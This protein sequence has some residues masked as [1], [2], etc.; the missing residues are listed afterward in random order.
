LAVRTRLVGFKETV[1]PVGATTADS[2]TVPAKLLTL[3]T[4]I[5][6]VVEE[7]AKTVS[8]ADE[9]EM[10]KSLKPP[11]SMVMVTG[12]ASVP[13]T[14]VTVTEYDPWLAVEAT[15]TVRV[16]LA[17]TMVGE[18]TTR[19]GLTLAVTSVLDVE[20]DRAT[21]PVNPFRPATVIIVLF[22]APGAT[23]RERAL[24]ES[25]KSVTWT[26]IDTV[27]ERVAPLESVIVP[28]TVPS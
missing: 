9:A 10:A 18:R 12:F 6:D 5:V 14:P 15:R 20:T 4:V 1:G 23:L 19:T 22:E 2:E 17:E 8:V 7:P 26:T 25:E 3:D 16:E 11:T 28:L 24:A 27:W 13:L 21:P